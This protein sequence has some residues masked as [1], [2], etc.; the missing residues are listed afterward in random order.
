[1]GHV[2][3]LGRGLIAQFRGHNTNYEVVLTLRASSLLRELRVKSATSEISREAR[4][5]AKGREDWEF[6]M[7][8]APK[9]FR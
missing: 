3:Y 6:R 8:K 2:G 9:Q 5:G 4:E 1:M 7:P